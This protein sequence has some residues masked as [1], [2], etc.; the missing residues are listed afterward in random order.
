M[1]RLNLQIIIKQCGNIGWF[2]QNRNFDG[3]V[4]M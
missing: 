2:M 4:M 1:I 3:M